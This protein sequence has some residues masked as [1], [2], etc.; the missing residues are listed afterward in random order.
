[1]S[2]YEYLHV[3]PHKQ[4]LVCLCISNNC[5]LRY[6]LHLSI[7]IYCVLHPVLQIHHVS[8]HT[9]STFARAANSPTYC[10]NQIPLVILRTDKRSATISLTC[11]DPSFSV[12]CTAHALWN[13]V[14]QI[15]IG[16][17]ARVSWDQ[18][19]LSL[20]QYLLNQTAITDIRC[21]NITA[22]GS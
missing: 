20:L 8:I 22:T 12:P 9:V 15:L 14:A 6:P 7:F 10:S 17:L 11:V 3:V 18:R 2:F 19:Y 4:P 13:S 21:F 16:R 1:M 5:Y